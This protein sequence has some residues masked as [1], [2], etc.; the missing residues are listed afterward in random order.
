MI[1]P[2]TSES[3]DSMKNAYEIQAAR[4]RRWQR[5]LLIWLGIW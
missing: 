2:I 4:I 1:G 3:S 5:R